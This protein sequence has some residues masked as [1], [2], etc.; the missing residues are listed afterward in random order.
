MT[1]IR[2]MII[3][4]QRP[5][6]RLLETFIGRLEH[7]T[8]V[9]TC[10]NAMDAMKILSEN[11]I[12]LVFLDIHLPEMD[13]LSFLKSLS[14]R[15]DIIITTAYPEHAIE[16]FELNVVDY[17]LKPFLFERFC[18]AVSRYTEHSQGKPAT[19]QIQSLFIKLDGDYVR[20]DLAKLTYLAS[21]GNFLHVHMQED[22]Y[23]IL[24]TLQSWLSKLPPNFVR[25]HRSYIVNLDFVDRISGN[26][27]YVANTSI[28]IGRLYKDKLVEHVVG[29]S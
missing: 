25:V 12:D 19:E 18:T 4:D 22:R 17:M 27:I 11:K 26:Q 3:E 28:P 2:C 29:K 24:G 9:A 21:D 14:T 10:G 13:G 6:Q 8:L 15:P 16:G 20:L 1:N 23:H 7:L 5:A